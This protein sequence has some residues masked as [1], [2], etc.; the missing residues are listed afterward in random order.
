LQPKRN[1]FLEIGVKV[2]DL[3]GSMTHPKALQ[4]FR[5]TEPSQAK[6]PKGVKTG[7]VSLPAN[8]YAAR[9]STAQTSR[10]FLSPTRKDSFVQPPALDCVLAR[11]A[12]VVRIC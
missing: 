1:I 12:A 8:T 6:A 10:G 4:A 5:D 7:S 9:T 2:S 3:L 11:L